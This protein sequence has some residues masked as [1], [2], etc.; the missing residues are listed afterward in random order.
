[1]AR[2]ETWFE[3]LGDTEPGQG[4][5][6]GGWLLIAVPRRILRHPGAGGFCTSLTSAS[7]KVCSPSNRSVLLSLSP[8]A[9]RADKDAID[10]QR[11]AE[12]LLQH[13]NR[14]S[15]DKLLLKDHRTKRR[16]S[17]SCTAAS[18]GTVGPWREEVAAVT[19]P[20][21]YTG[22]HLPAQLGP[23]DPQALLEWFQTGI[24][25]LSAVCA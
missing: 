3:Q 14:V 11:E 12:C 7:T 1:L 15:I 21:S 10:V 18:A 13:L 17:Q 19:V 6:L 22:I 8:Q 2:L 25:N 23:K 20:D 9:S 5:A 24:T 4:H 16:S